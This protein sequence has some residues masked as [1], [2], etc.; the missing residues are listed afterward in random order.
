MIMCM[1]ALPRLYMLA[2]GGIDGKVILWNIAA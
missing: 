2:T 1:V